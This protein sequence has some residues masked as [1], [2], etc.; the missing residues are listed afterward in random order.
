VVVGEGGVGHAAVLEQVL[1]GQGVGDAVEGAAFGLAFAQGGIDGGA[2]VDG[3]NVLEHL[4][5]AGPGIDFDFG[6]VGGER[7]RGF[8]G[9]VGAVADDLVLVF[10][11]EGVTGDI[12]VGHLLGAVGGLDVGVL[13][14]DL[15]DG[16]VEHLGAGFED[17]ALGVGSGLAGGLAGEVGGGGGVGAD[18]EGRHVG[19]GRI[20]DHLV[21]GGGEFLGGDL[22]E[23]GIGAGAQVSGADEEVERAVFVDFDGGAAHV[24]VGN[25]GALHE[26]GHADAAAV[27]AGFS[28]PVGA[29][30]PADGGGAF[31]DAFAEGA[32]ADGHGEA[33]LAFAEGGEDGGT[34]AGL[35]MV[36]AAEFERV[37]ADGLGHLVHGGFHGEEG[38]GGA[39][40]AVGAAD[41]Q[42]GVVDLAEEVDVVAAVEGQNLGA[43]AGDDGEAVAA[44]GAGVVPAVHAEGR[45]GAVLLDAGAQAD[46]DGVAGAAGPEVFLAGELP[47][48]G[49]SGAQGEQRDDVFEE[50]FLLGAEAAAD[51]GLDDA[52]F[53]DGDAE[54]L[55]DDAPAVEGHLG[56]GGD[57]DAPGGVDVGQRRVGFDGA[58]L[59]VGGLVGVV[60]GEI[61]VLHPLFEVAGLAAD[62][63]HEVFLRL[64]GDRDG[65]VGLGL[66]VD[67]G[68]AVGHGFVDGKDGR[69]QFVFDVDPGEGGLGLFGGL[70][71]DGGDAI[72]DK[73]HLGVED[74][75]VIRGGFGKPLAGGAVDV[76]GHVAMPQDGFHAGHFLG[77]GDVNGLDAGVGVGAP[78]HLDDEGVRGDEIADIGILAEG[79]LHGVHLADGVVDLLEVL[80]LFKAHGDP[81]KYSEFR[82]QNSEWRT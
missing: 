65:H 42:V 14:D 77:L 29:V 61:G 66:V 54:G 11:V 39:E 25:G 71:G 52:D 38:L 69:E 57:D 9:D 41:G 53:L 30:L 15:V 70:G 21:G 31:V 63:G 45:D 80:G 72:A 82:I 50:D 36:L 43:A 16:Q 75:R 35:D 8:F 47:E 6:V 19:V 27:A 18:V 44:V 55:G 49:A 1:F 10:L 34:L 58:V 78:E 74:E 3:G 2:A 23:D 46:A 32:G 59:G 60:E 73:A 62:A 81:F 40:A 68:G 56:G 64:V 5:Q 51:A 4:D 67:D 28:A 76:P 7:R 20:D 22:G 13:A 17:L 48:D 33:F 37:H 79:E 24:D 26:A 12:A